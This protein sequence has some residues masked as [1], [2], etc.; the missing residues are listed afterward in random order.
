MDDRV[1]VTA[2]DPAYSSPGAEPTAWESARDRVAEAEVSWLATVRP[3]GRPH[4]TP[5]LTV[6]FDGALHFCTGSEERKA[7]NL[8]DDARCVITTGSSALGQG[9]DVVVE[10]EA[11]LVTDTARL[12]ALADAW[13]TKYGEGWRFE[14][15]DGTFRDHRG[16]V[17]VFEVRPATVFG[18]AKGAEFSQTRWRFPAAEPALSA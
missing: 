14:V 13:V 15:R 9:L 3:D 7:R 18:F 2:L 10:G 8:A 11:R 12:H 16:D 4:V 5:L 1:P 17:P 6:W